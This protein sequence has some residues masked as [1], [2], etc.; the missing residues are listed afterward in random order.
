MNYIIVILCLL[1][2]SLA[3]AQDCQNFKDSGDG[4]PA[5]YFRH[6]CEGEK[7]LKAS[8]Y[9]KAV[10]EIKQ[11]LSIEFHESSNYELNV[12]LAEALCQLGRKEEAKR[13]IQEFNCMA[14]VELLEL[15][16]Y[17]EEGKPNSKLTPKCFDEM[18]VIALG[19]TSEGKANLLKR[20][21]RMRQI[22]NE[23]KGYN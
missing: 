17:D 20:R 10:A 9:Y 12:D 2:A 5:A 8:Q 1:C 3:N 22:E 6:K 18:C 7:A 21:E 11:A 16:C 13:I 23:C 4:I 19:L 14:A 15:D